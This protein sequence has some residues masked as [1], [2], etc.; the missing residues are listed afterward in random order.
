MPR[1]AR[2]EKYQN[3]WNHFLIYSFQYLLDILWWAF[4]PFIQKQQQQRHF[5]FEKTTIKN[6]EWSRGKNIWLEAISLQKRFQTPESGKG[7]IC[8]KIWLKF[9]FSL[10][11]MSQSP[12]LNLSPQGHEHGV[13]VWPPHH[14]WDLFCNALLSPGLPRQRAQSVPGDIGIRARASPSPWDIHSHWWSFSITF[15][16]SLMFA[17][18]SNA[19]SAT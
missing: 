15:W 7:S 13:R 9:L 14:C 6:S 12:Y 19:M 8:I 5:H 10:C 18:G 11:W 17:S 4:V 1:K 16:N 3:P 2:G